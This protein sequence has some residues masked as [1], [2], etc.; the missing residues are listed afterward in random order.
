M[1]RR[2]KLTVCS[3]NDSMTVCMHDYGYMIVWQYD[4]MSVLVYMIVWQYDCMYA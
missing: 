4:C 3:W 1:K 2:K